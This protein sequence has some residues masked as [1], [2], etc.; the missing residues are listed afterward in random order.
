MIAEHY[1][2]DQNILTSEGLQFL[3]FADN[4]G[5]KKLYNY[6]LSSMR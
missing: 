5:L 3:D 4:R 6:N 1:R 2:G